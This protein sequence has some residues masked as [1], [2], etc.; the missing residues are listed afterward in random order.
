MPTRDQ[1]T[2]SS[3]YGITICV[4]LSYENM[5]VFWPSLDGD[6]DEIRDGTESWNGKKISSL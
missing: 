4:V 5:E 3:T 2:K 1:R 6:F